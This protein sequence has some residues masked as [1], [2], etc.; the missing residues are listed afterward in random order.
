[1]PAHRQD[2]LA[3]LTQFARD[4]AGQDVIEYGILIATIVVVILLGVNAFGDRINTWFQT[5]AGHIT[6]VGT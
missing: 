5:L 4:E 6:T 1:M 2:Y 3:R